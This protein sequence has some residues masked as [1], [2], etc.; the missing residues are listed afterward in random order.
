VK[1]YLLEESLRLST[2]PHY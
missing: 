2:Y 1:A